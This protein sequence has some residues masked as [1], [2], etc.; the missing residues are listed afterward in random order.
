MRG[1]GIG[2]GPR[3]Q[4][5][6]AQGPELPSVLEVLGGPRLDHD[7]LGLEQPLVG[8]ARVDAIPLVVVDI[9]GGAA[10]EADD[11]ASPA[12]IVDQRHLLGQADRMVQRHLRHREADLDALGARGERGG[13]RHGI[14]VGADAV[15]MVLGQPQHL[16]AERVAEARLAQRLLDDLLVHRGVHRRRKQEVAEFHQ[17]TLSRFP[18][19]RILLPSGRAPDLGAEIPR[20]GSRCATARSAGLDFRCPWWASA[21]GRWRAT[22]TARSRTTRPSRPSIAPSTAASTAWTPR[23]PTAAATPRRSSGA[24]SRGGARTSSS[25]PSA[26]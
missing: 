10:A 11:Q 18:P 17:R 12:D 23:R 19:P 9:V 4:Q 3:A 8:L 14:D 26:A 5:G 13:E 16:H 6:Q 22:A 15:E 21:A 1:C 2:V 7:V 20:G 24:P 25:S